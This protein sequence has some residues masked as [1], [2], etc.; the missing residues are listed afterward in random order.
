MANFR[1]ACRWDWERVIACVDGVRCRRRLHADARDFYQTRCRSLACSRGFFYV[2]VPLVGLLGNLRRIPTPH[3]PRLK[4]VRGLGCV[5][6]KEKAVNNRTQP[7][8]N[9]LQH[10]VRRDP[11]P[12]TV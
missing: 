8:S 12:K 11:L 3:T 4:G 10:R 7:Y 1:R 9:R 2:A 5:L 6:C